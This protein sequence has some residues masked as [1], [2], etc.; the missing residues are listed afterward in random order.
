MSEEQIHDLEYQF[1][2]VYTFDS[3]P[4]SK[5]HI[6]FVNP[7]SEE[8]KKIRTVLVKTKTADELYPFKPS[9]VFK[10]V[11]KESGVR[12]TSHNHIQAWKYYRVRPNKNSRDRANTNKDYCI[13]HVA[14]GDYTYSESWVDF[15]IDSVNNSEEFAKIKAYKF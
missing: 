10:M 4:K 6:R 13:Y 1:R 9:M 12:F 8:G 2:V 15:L 14:H 3:A 5:S 11:T 7:E